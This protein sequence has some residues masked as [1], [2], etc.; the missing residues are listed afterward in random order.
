MRYLNKLAYAFLAAI[1]GLT[2]LTSCEGGDL[3]SVNSPDWLQSKID[4]I[5]NSRDP[6]EDI[7]TI[8]A[9][10]Y[11]TGWWAEFSKYYVI[12]QGCKWTANFNLHINPAATNTYKNYALI[13]T[14]D[15]DRGGEGY[16]EYGAIRFDNQPSGN[17][18]WGTYI[19]RSCVTSTLTFETDTDPGV[20]RL[21][22]DV[23]LTVDYSDPFKFVV[24]MTNGDVTKVYNQP[25]PLPNLNSTADNKNIRC[26]IVPEGSYI[27]FQ[28]SKIE[29]MGADFQDKQPIS[30]I[31]KGVPDE[32]LLGTDVKKVLESVTA[33]ITFEGDFTKTVQASDMIISILPDIETPGEKQVIAIYNKTFFGVSSDK[34]VYT[35][36]ST[37]VVNELSAFLQTVV[38]PT[39]QVI[40]AEDNTSPFWDVH[41]ENIKI[42]PRETAVATFTNYTCGVSNWNN[43]CIVLCKANNAEYAVV[44][45]DDY[46]WGDGYAACK[47]AGGFGDDNEKWTAWRSA[48]N[49]AK[50]TTYVSNNG[51]GT[52]DVKAVFVGNDGE[53][54]VQTYTGINTID[55][56]DLYFRFTVDNCHLVFDKGIGAEDNSSPFWDDHSANI[57]VPSQ[58]KCNMSFT[59]YTSSAENWNNFCVVLCKEN[60]AE[61]AVVRADNHGWGDGYGACK[62][63]GG[64]GDDQA[65]WAAWRSAMNGA[66]VDLTVTNNGNGT[67][68]VEAVMH[69]TDG[70]DYI[71]SYIG[72]NT[73]DKDNF[74]FRLTVDNCHL[75][76][77]DNVTSAK[78][79]NTKSRVI[80]TRSYRRR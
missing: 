13:I 22:G 46:G 8:G 38:F 45:A 1:L 31:L 26:F 25:K 72:I 47:H 37:K 73:V 20:E 50:I 15:V 12:P 48:I 57:K 64:F 75:N 67:A 14:N 76:F 58:T 77:Y 63:T 78:S 9:S 4:S 16:Q 80:S 36:S 5:N 52:A 43:Y 18:E 71:Q 2:A 39:P 10:D 29:N 53:T 70:V 34:P 59:N 74:Y 23:T 21:G 44:R 19:D 65:K 61:Y 56:D 49:G 69:G 32:I 33:E 79:F 24:T 17:S 55:K 27:D 51:D 6:Y 40:G 68:D 11:S 35:N 62:P 30:M 3:Y 7:Y 28:K 66:K 41:T 60:N 42:A 54:Y